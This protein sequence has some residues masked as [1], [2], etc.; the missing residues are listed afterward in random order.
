L[1]RKDLGKEVKVYELGQLAD[2]IEN[3]DLLVNAT[4]VGMSP[5]SEASLVPAQ[6]L[7]KVPAVI[8]IVYNPLETRLLREAK[9]AG[10]KV[11]GGV[12]MLAWQGALAFEKWTGQPAPLDLMRAEAVK[13]LEKR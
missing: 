3:T 6:L 12:D 9:A 5:A 7:G 1:I 10:A 4:S 8:D 11:I 13:M 2:A